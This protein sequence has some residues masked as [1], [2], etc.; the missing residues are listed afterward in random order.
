ML[1]N[2]LFHAPYGNH[3]KQTLFTIT[4]YK[5]EGEGA[6]QLSSCMFGGCMNANIGSTDMGVSK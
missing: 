4:I 6:A 3:H 1:Y 2:W 5:M